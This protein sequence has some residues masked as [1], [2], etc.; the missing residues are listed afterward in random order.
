M[1]GCL[2]DRGPVRPPGPQGG[3]GRLGGRSCP[4]G[5]CWGPCPWLRG[6]DGVR[7]SCGT[8]FGARTY[9]GRVLRCLEWFRDLVDPWRMRRDDEQASLWVSSPTIPHTLGF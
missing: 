9:L 4:R 8:T 3:W 5:F 1:D 7:G 6:G 2:S